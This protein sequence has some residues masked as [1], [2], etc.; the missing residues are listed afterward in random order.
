MTMNEGVSCPIP[1]VIQDVKTKFLD[2]LNACNVIALFTSNYS[3]LA[4][5]LIRI[6]IKIKLIDNNYNYYR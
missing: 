1:T 4:Y 2:H 6:N 3:V 5:Q